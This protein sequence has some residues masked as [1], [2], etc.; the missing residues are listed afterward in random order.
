MISFLS[1]GKFKSNFSF[2]NILIASKEV[3]PQTPQE[4]LVTKFLFSFPISKFF[5][6]SMVASIIFFKL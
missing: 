5:V 6:S 4:E 3:L 2:L 1:L